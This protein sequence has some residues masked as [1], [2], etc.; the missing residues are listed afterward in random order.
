MGCLL[1]VN[2]PRSSGGVRHGGGWNIGRMIRAHQWHMVA[3][4]GSRAE[5]GNLWWNVGR[6]RRIHHLKHLRKVQR[7]RGRIGGWDGSIGIREGPGWGR[8]A[9][10]VA[11]QN[12]WLGCIAAGRGVQPATAGTAEVRGTTGRNNALEILPCTVLFARGTEDIIRVSFHLQT[13]EKRDR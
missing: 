11:Q 10:M 8:D 12:T 2:G 3:G 7:S 4:A 9:A 1:E 6:M 13:W 5:S